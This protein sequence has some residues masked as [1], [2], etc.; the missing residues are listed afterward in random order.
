MMN[1][2]PA[3]ILE[4]TIARIINIDKK[5]LFLLREKVCFFDAKVYKM[6]SDWTKRNRPETFR[7]YMIDEEGFFSTGIVHRVTAFLM[8]QNISPLVLDNRVRPKINKISFR[9]KCSEPSPYNDQAKA[10]AALLKAGQGIAQMPTGIGK[11]RVIKDNIQ[12]L[13]V[14][15]LVVT[16]SINLKEQMADY[17][18]SCF[19]AEMV[20]IYDKRYDC[21]PITVINFQSIPSLDDREFKDFDL[22]QFDEF[23]RM[24]CDTAREKSL[25]HFNNF[26]YRFGLTATNF[27]A[28]DCETILLESVL[29]NTVFS[30]TILEAI[31]KKYIVPI[32]PVF[33]N[34]QNEGI[35]SEEDITYPEAFSSF[36]SRNSERNDKI[37]ETI[38]KMNKLGLPNLTLVKHIEHG[39]GLADACGA[40][41]LN[42]QDANAK[43]N[44][45]KIKAFNELKIKSI[46]GTS[47]IGE[48]VDTKACAAVINAKSGKSKKE[49][50][51]N[52][53]RCVRKFKDKEIGFYFDFID[54]GNKTTLAHSRERYRIIKKEFGIVPKIIDV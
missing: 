53:G 40:E 13:G 23:H 9:M 44:M 34:L 30:M 22:V 27:A 3:I 47:V 18:E 28:S 54:N 21:K 52:I 1:N 25:T 36:V 26:Y 48:G 51:Q 20:G 8:T 14:R 45:E 39:K 12:I 10:T 41:F 7:T 15:T 50:L 37:L 2:N 38:A 29:S 5:V 6:S 17:L 33:F 49:L 31:Q 42:G 43:D 46:V 32:L 35:K 24:I 11:S 19:G 16:P 4:N